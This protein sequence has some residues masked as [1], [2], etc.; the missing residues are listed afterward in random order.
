M[1]KIISLLVFTLLLTIGFGQKI[2]FKDKTIWVDGMEWGLIETETFGK[3]YTFT[4][5]SGEDFITIT[6]DNIGTGKMGTSGKEEVVNFM[7]VNFLNTDW[8]NFEVNA[9]TRKQIVKWLINTEVLK[10]GKFDEANA[11]KFKNKYQQD[12]SSKYKKGGNTIII[13]N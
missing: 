12:I 9:N 3:K 13:N 1:K 4:T 2:K 5:L 7:T 10:E 6:H 8:G 11:E